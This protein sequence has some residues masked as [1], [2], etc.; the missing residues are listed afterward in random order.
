[1]NPTGRKLIGQILCE[2]GYLKQSQI[3]K[4]LAKQKEGKHRK[5]GQILVDFGYITFGQLNAVLALQAQQA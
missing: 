5:L 2:N 3:E 1:M 4:A